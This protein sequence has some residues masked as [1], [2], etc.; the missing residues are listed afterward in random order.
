MVYSYTFSLV[1]SL[2]VPMG[3]YCYMFS[4]REKTRYSEGWSD[5]YTCIMYVLLHTLEAVY[6]AGFL[7]YKF[8]LST[9][10]YVY[11]P[12][13]INTLGMMAVTIGWL[14][15]SEMLRRRSIELSFHANG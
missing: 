12:E 15:F 1:L 8:L 5:G 9:E 2:I 3:A 7:P 14:Q 11:I 13:Y 4:G 6:F 10:T